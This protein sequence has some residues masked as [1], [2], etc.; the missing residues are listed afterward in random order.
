MK[1][2]LAK[3]VNPTDEEVYKLAEEI[4]ETEHR[5]EH[6]PPFKGTAS[7]YARGCVNG[8]AERLGWKPSMEERK[9]INSGV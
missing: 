7:I 5:N 3:H 9:N 2:Q 4:Y 8:A 1:L 6:M